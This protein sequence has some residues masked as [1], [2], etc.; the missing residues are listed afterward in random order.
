M[1][2]ATNGTLCNMQ[3]WQM[4]KHRHRNRVQEGQA[5][6]QFLNTW[7]HPLMVCNKPRLT[8]PPPHTHT[9]ET[10]LRPWK[11]LPSVAYTSRRSQY[12]FSDRHTRLIGFVLILWVTYQSDRGMAYKACSG[13]YWCAYK[14]CSGKYWCPEWHTRPIVMSTDTL[15]D[16]QG[17]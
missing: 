8:K 1:V 16:I 3:G 12:L 9:I 6:Q 13:K 2:E 14:A 7:W 11:L 10:V 5:P 17:P 4:R 15:N